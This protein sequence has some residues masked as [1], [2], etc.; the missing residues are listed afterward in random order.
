MTKQYLTK[1]HISTQDMVVVAS[2]TYQQVYFLEE[3]CHQMH[4]FTEHTISD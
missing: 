3:D 1:K 4:S 2:K